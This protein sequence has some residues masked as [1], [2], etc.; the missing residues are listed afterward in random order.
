MPGVNQAS[1]H[2][3]LEPPRPH[4]RKDE[5]RRLTPIR[6]AVKNGKIVGNGFSNAN[7]TSREKAL[8]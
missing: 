6:F 3:T 4:P 1:G 8:L 5:E 7:A 2:W